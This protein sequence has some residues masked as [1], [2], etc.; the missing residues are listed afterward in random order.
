MEGCF[1]RIPPPLFC[2]GER[3]LQWHVNRQR[4]SYVQYMILMIAERC[5]VQ[6]RALCRQTY[7]TLTSLL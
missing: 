1:V 3:L 6:H 2:Q 5:R 7:V 4:D